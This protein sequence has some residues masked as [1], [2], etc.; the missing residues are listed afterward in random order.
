MRMDAGNPASACRHVVVEDKREEGRSRKTWSQ[1]K[2]DDLRRMKLNPK[3]AQDRRLW[4]RAIM[5][6]RPTHAS[7]ETYTKR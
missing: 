4:T 5:R 2:S 3:F 6:P 1:L 7:M